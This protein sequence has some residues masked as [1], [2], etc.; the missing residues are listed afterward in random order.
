MSTVLTSPW[1]PPGAHAVDEQVGDH[2]RCSEIPRCLWIDD[3]LSI[4]PSQLDHFV[5]YFV[6][7]SDSFGEFL[8]AAPDQTCR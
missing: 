5:A 1:Y 6:E 7:V 4:G 2:R 3:T 8:R